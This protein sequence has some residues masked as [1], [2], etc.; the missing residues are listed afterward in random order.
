MS[1]L[2]YVERECQATLTTLRDALAPGHPMERHF[3][4]ELMGMMGKCLTHL[5]NKQFGCEFGIH[6]GRCTCTKGLRG[7]CVL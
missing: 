7:R 4:M 1:G 6:A 3:Y 5:M 2:S